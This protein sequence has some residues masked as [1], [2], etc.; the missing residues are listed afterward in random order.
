MQDHGDRDLR[1]AWHDR[2][3]TELRAPWTRYAPLANDF[4]ARAIDPENASIR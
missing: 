4:V 1:V 3:V 2:P